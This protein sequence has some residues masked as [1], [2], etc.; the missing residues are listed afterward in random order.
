[1]HT[2]PDSA[3]RELAFELRP[4][5]HRREAHVSSPLHRLFLLFLLLL[6]GEHLLQLRLLGVVRDLLLRFLIR[7]SERR[8]YLRVREIFTLAADYE[9]TAKETMQFFRIIQNKLHFASTGKTAAEIIAERADANLPNMGLT[10]WKGEI[11][12][13]G[14][15]TVAKNYLK[16]DEI[17]GLN[18]IVVMWLD[19]AEDQAKRRRQVFLKDWQT[20]LDEFL[21]FNEREVLPDAGSISKK[22]AD[23]RAAAAYETFA[24]RRREALEQAGAEESI[25]RLED[26][27]RNPPLE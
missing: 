4:R 17:A 10:V 18:R 2:L 25:K 8:M 1:M 23:E 14:D 20:K 21:R 27:S 24:K 15:V 6:D 19:F 5:T 22:E 16:D 26:L 7:A 11:V 13:K 12:R 9:P 3:S